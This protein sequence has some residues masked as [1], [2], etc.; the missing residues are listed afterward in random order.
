MQISLSQAGIFTVNIFYILFADL[1]G[2]SEDET[3]LFNA[4][5]GG[6]TAVVKILIDFGG[7]DQVNGIRN[8]KSLMEIARQFSAS[9]DMIKILSGWPFP[10]PLIH[11]CS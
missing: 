10:Y 5:K 8:G 11:A 6:N 3:C 7:I 1:L 2:L 9:S 4:V